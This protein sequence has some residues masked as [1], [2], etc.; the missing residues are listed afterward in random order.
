MS[1]TKGKT[2]M[3]DTKPVQKTIFDLDSMTEVLVGKEH[4]VAPEVTSV[5]QALQLLG[6]DTKRLFTIIREG[7]TAEIG[8]A[9]RNDP[10]G[11]FAADDEGDF[12]VPFNGTVA[13]IKAVNSLVLTLAKTALGWDKNM[14]KDQKAKVKEAAMEAIK[15]TPLLRDGLKRTAA[16]ASKAAV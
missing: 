16:L 2:K 12:T 13:D 10:S 9:A 7:L 4:A 5:E 3:A 11:W 14:T 1:P 6:N 8:D 15:T